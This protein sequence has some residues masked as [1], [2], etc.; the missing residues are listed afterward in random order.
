MAKRA[1]W[2]DRDGDI[3]AVAARRGHHV[4]S[5]RQFRHVEFSFAKGDAEQFLRLAGRERRIDAFDR[6]AP[7]D[8]RTGPV[9]RRAGDGQAQLAW[10]HALFS[11]QRIRRKRFSSVP[12]PS[13]ETDTTSPLLRKTGGLRPMPT[14][15]GVPVAMISPG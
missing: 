10:G 11:S 8:H 6:D 3:V 13:I 12:M 1:R 2:E 15:A 5:H 9:R 7:V 14:P 4:A